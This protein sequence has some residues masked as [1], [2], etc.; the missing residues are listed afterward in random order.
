M[1]DII[2]WHTYAGGL[3]C[4]VC[5]CVCMRCLLLLGGSVVCFYARTKGHIALFLMDGC[6]KETLCLEVSCTYMPTAI[7]FGTIAATLSL[8]L[9]QQMLLKLFRRLLVG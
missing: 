3:R 6:R 1:G 7:A 4:L 9:W 5:V 2:T 8:F